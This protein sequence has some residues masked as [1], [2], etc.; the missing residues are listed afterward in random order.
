[1]KKQ[2]KDGIGVEGVDQSKQDTTKLDLV[3]VSIIL[4]PLRVQLDHG[5]DTH[6]GNASL[7]GTLQLLDLTHARL[8]D[9]GLEGVVNTT[10][11]QV[12]TIV[13]VGLLLGDSL[14]LL[15][16]IAVLHTLR[17]S[18]SDTELGDKLGRVLSGV[19]G[20]GLGDSQEGLGEF[21]DGELLARAL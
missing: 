11:G 12:E 8:E 21:T 17:Q 4:L 1:M 3:T 15:V 10:L 7:D 20:Q 19:D 6:N 13:A 9:T 18:M 16:G 5:I 2:G 14:L